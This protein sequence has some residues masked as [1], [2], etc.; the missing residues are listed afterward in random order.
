MAGRRKSTYGGTGLQWPRRPV[1]P[2]ASLAGNG[3]WHLRTGPADPVEIPRSKVA[4]TSLFIKKASQEIGMGLREFRSTPSVRQRRSSFSQGRNAEGR[5]SPVY[6]G[7]NTWAEW[8][9]PQAPAC[10]ST[11]DLAATNALSPSSPSVPI[12]QPLGSNGNCTR[13]YQPTLIRASPAQIF[14]HTEMGAP[15]Q[16]AAPILLT[17]SATYPRTGSVRWRRS[18]SNHDPPS[19]A[20]RP[21]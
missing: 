21:R 16:V 11:V 14:H 10:G 5:I 6:R 19:A 20:G 4:A 17:C 2:G 15:R 13:W 8:G 1:D 7:D 12:Y 18:R 9:N 3:G